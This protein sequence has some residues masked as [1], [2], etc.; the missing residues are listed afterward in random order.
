LKFAGEN[1]DAVSGLNPTAR[2][3]RITC[4]IVDA[5]T[6]VRV[7]GARRSR[8]FNAR[9]VCALRLSHSF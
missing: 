9:T 3:A 8:R 1:R 5:A 2:E 7:K 4:A 6:R